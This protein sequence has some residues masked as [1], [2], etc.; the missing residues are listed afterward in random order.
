[1]ALIEK[2]KIK[3]C[4]QSAQQ[5][6]VTQALAQ[7]QI[8]QRL[9][10]LLAKSGKSDFPTVL[11][12]GCG[13]GDFTQRLAN[14][15]NVEQWLLNDLYQSE[16]ITQLITEKQLPAQFLLGDIEQI[17]VQQQCDLLCSA[18]TV[19]WLTQQQQF[20][21]NCHQQLNEQ[22]ILLFN[23]FAPTN[24]YE[25]RTLT[26]IGLTYPTLE[27]WQRWLEDYFIVQE[28]FTETIQLTFASPLEVLQ[29]L[30]ATGVT[31]TQQQVWTKSKLNNFIAQYQEQ[32]T[33]QTG[34]V[35]LTYCPVYVIAE[36]K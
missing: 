21:A 5:S 22:G 31:A 29:H 15:A 16:A 12:I 35:S 8:N 34:Q 24:L 11:E 1:M 36:K 25:I 19:Q 18:S 10:Q 2:S 9:I 13:T 23:S 3:T 27:Q 30:R 4:F 7:Q 33:L 32:F 28:L 20:I 17:A 6:Y 14:Y 26:G